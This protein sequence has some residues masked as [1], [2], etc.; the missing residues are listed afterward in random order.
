[1]RAG[2]NTMSVQECLYG[3]GSPGQAFKL[4]ENTLI[5]HIEELDKITRGK[6]TLDET[7]GL[8]QI[9]RRKEM[10][11]LKLLEDYYRR[12]ASA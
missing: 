1:M 5:F 4:D 2:R 9:Y 3:Q 8:K 7:A 11:A 12:E 6:I 10:D